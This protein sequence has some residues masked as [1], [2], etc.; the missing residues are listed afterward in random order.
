MLKIFSFIQEARNGRRTHSISEAHIFM[1][2]FTSKEW[3]LC[4][5]KRGDL[6]ANL[7]KG[8]CE[9]S[10]FYVRIASLLGE[11]CAPRFSTLN[12]S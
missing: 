6:H 3:Q 11:A 9:P 12:Q 8:R 2:T 5:L 10:K 1:G 7:W 4:T